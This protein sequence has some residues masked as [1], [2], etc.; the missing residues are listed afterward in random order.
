MA[1]PTT[2]MLIKTPFGEGTDPSTC[3][4]GVT[5]GLGRGATPRSDIRHNFIN[6]GKHF[7]LSLQ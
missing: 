6:R 5:I 4:G 2:N 1:N 7:M 3:L